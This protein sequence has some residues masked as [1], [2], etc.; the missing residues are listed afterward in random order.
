ME[1]ALVLEQKAGKDV[2]SQQ[3]S[4]TEAK[5]SLEAND[6]TAA[7]GA[8]KILEASMMKT[9]SS[10][11]TAAELDT[12]SCAIQNSDFLRLD[13]G[14]AKSLYEKAKVAASQNDSQNSL[15]LTKQAMES[16]NRILPSYIAGEMRKAKVSLREIKLMNVD[17]AAPVQMLKEAND[18]VSKG[19]YCSALAHIKSFKEFV[20]KA[21]Q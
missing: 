17:I 5:N 3:A 2:R 4:L 10:T 6:F 21:S 11:M 20:Q 19:D 1:S 16:L 8:L 13:I 18:H 7:S 12:I 9:S 14:E 15:Q